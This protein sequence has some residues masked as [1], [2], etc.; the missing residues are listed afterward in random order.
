MIWVGEPRIGFRFDFVIDSLPAIE[1]TFIVANYLLC[2]SE[3]V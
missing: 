2:G 1:E 3:I